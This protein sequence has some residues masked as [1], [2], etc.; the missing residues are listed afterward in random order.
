[1]LYSVLLKYYEYLFVLKLFRH[2]FQL[3][4]ELSNDVE[5]KSN[6][7]LADKG[8][9]PVAEGGNKSYQSGTQAGNNNRTRKGKGQPR[10]YPVTKDEPRGQFTQDMLRKVFLL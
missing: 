7:F 1:M 10:F 5:G 8:G 4:S 2:R 6:N 9:I 3:E